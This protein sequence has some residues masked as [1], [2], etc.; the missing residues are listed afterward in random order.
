MDSEIR[1]IHK[2]Y[3]SDISLLVDAYF[4]YFKICYGLLD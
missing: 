4:S 1:Q 3:D 2:N